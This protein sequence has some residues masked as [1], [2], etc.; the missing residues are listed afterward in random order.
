MVCTRCLTFNHASFIV[1]AMNGFTM[2]ITTFPVISVIVDDASTD[3]EPDVIRRYLA[4]NFLSPFLVEETDD[5]ILISARHKTNSNCVFAV[6]L[7]KYNHYSVNKTKEPYFSRWQRESKYI[8]LCEGDDY[9][10]NPEKLQ[11]QVC[12]LETHSEYIMTCSKAGLFSER[13]RRLIGENYCYCHNRRVSIKD[14]IYRGGLFI[15]TCSI[16]Y[17]KEVSDDRPSYWANCLVGDY[18]LQIACVLKGNAW[19]FND[20]MAVY[21]IDNPSSWMGSQ[22]WYKGGGDPARLRIV[23]SQLRMF[24]GFCK[25]YPI[26]KELFNNKIADHINR[27]IPGRCVGRN[28][29]KSYLNVFSEEIK[30]YN[31]KWKLDLFMRQSRIPFFR[32]F[33]QRVFTHRYRAKNRFYF[34]I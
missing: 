33:Y 4:D 20:M 31:F 18:P 11:T 17:K 1:D 23:E 34:D 3:G 13:K 28:I 21:R 5:Y 30:E 7:L 26:Y 25:D 32:G 22:N 15:S 6:Y 24:R 12:F 16:V 8:A 2:Q 27:N 29:V 14:T 10:V 19:Y 9:W